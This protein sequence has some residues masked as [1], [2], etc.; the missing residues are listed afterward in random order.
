M[1][2]VNRRDLD[3]KHEVLRRHAHSHFRRSLLG[4][5]NEEAARLAELAPLGW[6]GGADI[7]RLKLAGGAIRIEVQYPFA[8][9]RAVARAILS[10]LLA[11]CKHHC[12]ELTFDGAFQFALWSLLE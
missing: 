10:Y 7:A 8:W 9:Q 1:E 2:K 12:V 5:A 6:W 4:N 3:Y 11:G